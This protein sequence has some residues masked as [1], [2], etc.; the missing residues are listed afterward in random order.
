MQQLKLGNTTSQKS[1]GGTD[2]PEKEQPVAELDEVLQGEAIAFLQS[3]IDAVG[4]YCLAPGVKLAHRVKGVSRESFCRALTSCAEW[5]G[6][7]RGMVRIP[8]RALLPELPEQSDPYE[9]L[10]FQGYV[11]YLRFGPKRMLE[12]SGEKTVWAEDC[13]AFYEYFSLACRRPTAEPPKPGELLDK[14]YADVLIS[15]I[16]LR[17]SRKHTTRDSLGSM[18]RQALDQGMEALW[19]LTQPLARK[20]NAPQSAGGE[21]ER[22]ALKELGRQ[23]ARIWDE[24]RQRYRRLFGSPPVDLQQLVDELLIPGGTGGEDP[25]SIPPEVWAAVDACLEAY[26]LPRRDQTVYGVTDRR[27]LKDDLRQTF[28][29]RGLLKPAPPPAPL[30]HSNPARQNAGGAMPA[31]VRQALGALCRNITS[32]TA[33]D[34]LDAFLSGRFIVTADESVFLCD[35]GRTLLANGLRI[36]L[37][38]HKAKLR[39]DESVVFA[40]FRQLR[41]NASCPPQE[42]GLLDPDDRELLQENKLRL[43][44][45]AKKAVKVLRHLRESGCLEVMRSPVEGAS[46]Y[47]NIRAA[48]VECPQLHMLVLSQDA[49]LADELREAAQNAVVVKVNLNGSLWRFPQSDAALAAILDDASPR[50]AP[51]AFERPAAAAPPP[52]PEGSRTGG[53]SVMLIAEDVDGNRRELPLGSQLGRGGEG[54]VYQVDGRTVAKIYH[55]KRQTK[56]Q[57][58]KLRYMLRADPHIKSLCWP[59]GLLYTPEGDWVG[60]LMPRATGVPLTV[61]YH[62]GRNYYKLVALKWTRRSLAKIAE[63]IAAVFAKMHANGIRM[64]DINP[65][66]FVIDPETLQ[67]ALVD[68]DSY[69]FGEFL[70]PVGTPLF[71]PP[72]V[73][74]QMR[75]AGQENYGFFR[76]DEHERYTLAVLLFEILMLG[77]APYEAR[78]TSADGV[79]DAIIAGRFPYPPSKKRREAEGKNELQEDSGKIPVGPTIQIWNHTTGDIKDSFYDTFTG[80]AERR[81]NAAQ[82]TQKMKKYCTEIAL[83]HSTDELAPHNYKVLDDSSEGGAKIEMID[84]EC[85]RCHV[86][87]NTDTGSYHNWKKR[88][89]PILCPQHRA[90][91]KNLQRRPHIV[92][93]DICHQDFETTC[94]EWIERTEKCLKMVCPVCSV[95]RLSCSHCHQTYEE[96]RERAEWAALNGQDLVCPKCFQLLFVETTCQRCGKT[97]SIRRETLERRRKFNDQVLCKNC[98]D[99]NKESGR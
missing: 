4:V 95:V 82:W 83:G 13:Y 91:R 64:G 20:A 26:N 38:K 85:E 30:S 75:Q 14:S 3:L 46:G 49:S 93:C 19:K 88:N 11:K 70:C 10:D 65:G 35:E 29:E 44:Q 71:T 37:V 78:G 1:G 39:L 87:F 58:E 52:A 92:T 6:K 47:E 17:N 51:L 97:F 62:P 68:C 12:Q 24:A 21:A 32:Q 53:G 69:Q 96:R 59:T 41:E 23:R 45:E 60:F 34:A 84:L 55:K 5:N 90:Q 76:T 31:A 42:L 99:Q 28:E 98:R 43:H 67:V 2:M 27:R 77:K 66:N 48:A 15:C 16:N 74:I 7:R 81:L 8:G 40:L 89:E 57:Q 94:L 72:E 33:P 63:N 18:T 80:P 9:Q 22:D 54:S 56:E 73:H 50:P 25:F 79:V 86:K 61:V 36:Q